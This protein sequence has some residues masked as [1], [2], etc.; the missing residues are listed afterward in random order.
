MRSN[1]DDA[2]HF[3][4][5]SGD[6]DSVAFECR[7]DGVSEL[8]DKTFTLGDVKGWLVVAFILWHIPHP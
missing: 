1:M 5:T 2:G 8:L 6:D 3:A 7:I 4:A